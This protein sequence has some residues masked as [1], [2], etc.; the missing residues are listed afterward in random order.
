MLLAIELAASQCV[1]FAQVFHFDNTFPCSQTHR[2][3]LR[4]EKTDFA[5]FEAI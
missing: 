5:R 4:V 3:I 1:N 2:T